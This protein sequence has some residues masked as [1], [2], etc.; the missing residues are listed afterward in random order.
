MSISNPYI[1]IILPSLNVAHYISECMDSVV[2]QTIKD[3]EIICVD[4]GSTDGTLEILELYAAKDD[5]ITIIRSDI[6]SYGYQLNLGIAK[7]R[8]KYIGIV[9]T[10]DYISPDMYEKLYSYVKDTNVDYVKGR[11]FLIFDFRGERVCI[12]WINEEYKDLYGQYLDLQKDRS[13]GMYDLTHIWTGIYRRDFLIEKELWFHES[14]GASY[15]DTSFSILVGLMADT[16][17][18]TDICSYHYRIDNMNS[19]V[20]SDSKIECVRDEYVYINA[21]LGRHN[22]A[23]ME[24]RSLV[25]R[26]KI[27]TYRWNFNRLS[28]EGRKQFMKAISEEMKVYLLGGLYEKVLTDKEKEDVKILTDSEY[29]YLEMQKEKE[30]NKTYQELIS[31]ILSGSQ[32]MIVGAGNFFE[33]WV[34]LKNLLKISFIIGVCDNNAAL[35]GT[36]KSGYGIMSVEEA[37]RKKWNGGWIVAN[38]YHSSEIVEQLISLGIT[39]D[40][41]YVVDRAIDIDKMIQLDTCMEQQRGSA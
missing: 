29:A 26:Y 17:V 8:G 38:K 13:Q 40:K 23:T 27:C 2:A 34:M 9:E 19:S 20:K 41:V 33:R 4:A 15:Q 1:S 14:P 3:I 12:P 24:N 11:F 30:V 37:V 21:Y 18:L 6:K 35:Q 5:R 25:D 31:G 28:Y 39:R 16:C 36:E 32:F 22:N 10:D 7:A